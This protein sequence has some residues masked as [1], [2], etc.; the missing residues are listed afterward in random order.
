MIPSVY[1]SLHM[2]F[3]R[4]HLADYIVTVDAAPVNTTEKLLNLS[5]VQYANGR[6]H[7]SGLVTFNE[8]NLT[9]E[10]LGFNAS[11]PPSVNNVSIVDGDYLD[12]NK[13]SSVLLDQR[14]AQEHDQS[15]GDNLT[16]IILGQ[17]HNF[18]IRGLFLSPEFLLAAVNPMAAYPTPGSLAAVIVPLKTLQTISGFSGYVNEFCVVFEEDV[19][20]ENS[21]DAVDDILQDYGIRRSV[22]QEDIF[23]ISFVETDLQFGNMFIVILTGII[24]AVAFFVVFSAMHR[25]VRSQRQEIGVLRGLGYNQRSILSQYIVVAI[26]LG[27]LSSFIG[28]LLFFPIGFPI[29]VEYMH[30]ISG[31]PLEVLTLPPE[32]FILALVFGPAT[33]SLAMVAA[34]WGATHL[35]PHNAM[36]GEMV[37]MKP[38]KLT[39]LERVFGVV[40]SPTYTT[41]YLFRQLSRRRIRSTLVV[42]ALSFCFVI[43]AIGPM[44]VSSFSV[45]FEYALDQHDKWDY[46]ASFASPL[47]PSEV[48]NLNLTNAETIVPFLRFG[49]YAIRTGSGESNKSVGVVAMPWNNTL[50][51]F[52]IREGQG[53]EQRRTILLVP[54]LARKL[55]VVIGESVMLYVADNS[56]EFEVAGIV[57]DLLGEAFI[58]LDD[59]HSLI[60]NPAATGLFLTAKTGRADQ[61]QKDL[62]KLDQVVLV[63]DR[64]EV[65]SGMRR[66]MG[67]FS[68]ILQIFTLLGLLMAMLIIGNLVLIG[69]LERQSEYSLMRA[70]GYGKR[71]IAK[72]VIGETFTLCIFGILV[73]I[74]LSYFL[75]QWIVTLPVLENIFPIYQ[76]FID[77]VQFAVVGII[78]IATA[79]IATVPSL[80][81]I[82]RI[83][84]HQVIR[85]RQLG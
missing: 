8:L 72:I 46:A 48:D 55:G 80:N 6:L 62:N 28:I 21:R 13:S 83:P 47:L 68:E 17:V 9:T 43:A 40:G 54:R 1:S 63:Q 4:L 25:L 56:T 69:S 38:V 45:S 34:A 50:H 67:Y 42:F 65:L 32:M 5:T 12:H 26:G 20:P 16:I 30:V 79:L 29:S 73:G 78:I 76:V 23:G 19:T 31:F 58:R 3:N 24:L 22:R 7:L 52:W 81:I 53:I 37:D 84:L 27:L 60:G 64:Q 39:V 15:V 2:V 14:F 66:M 18:T 36:R 59:A 61:L 33:T 77:W 51:T 75:T 49:G 41:R 74:P 35:N 11:I 71:S 44:M 57:R 85:E 82:L 10:L 70:I